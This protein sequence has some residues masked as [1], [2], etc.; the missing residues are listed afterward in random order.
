MDF[1]LS[2]EVAEYCAK[3]RAFVADKVLPLEA[4]PS[5]WDEHENIRLD[6]LE[7]LR[8]ATKAAGL[9]C[10]QIPK[11]L[12]GLGFP[13]VAMAAAYE[14]MGRS[15]FGPV[16]LLHAA[17]RAVIAAIARWRMDSPYAA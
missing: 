8:T 11:K 5:V 16:S 4:D 15:L 10:P 6:R 12:G 9:W 7:P 17:A 13:V 2:P 3:V 14:E 1:S